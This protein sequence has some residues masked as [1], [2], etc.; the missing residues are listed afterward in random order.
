MFDGFSDGELQQEIAPGKNRIF[1]LLGHLV[2]VGTIPCR[3]CLGWAR[4]CM[5][6]WIRSSYQCGPD[7]ARSVSAAALRQTCAKINAT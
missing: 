7:D 4:D 5:K 3:R 1:Y 2:A 6:S